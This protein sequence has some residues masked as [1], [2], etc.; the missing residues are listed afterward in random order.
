VSFG[1]YLARPRGAPIGPLRAEALIRRVRGGSLSPAELVWKEGFDGWKKI[2]QVPELIGDLL[3]ADDEAAPDTPPETIRE[4]SLR[5]DHEPPETKRADVP[6]D[7]LKRARGSVVPTP[8]RSNDGADRAAVP[9]RALPDAVTETNPALRA[10]AEEGETTESLPPT[11]DFG[12][13]GLVIVTPGAPAPARP[14]LALAP[15]ESIPSH[16]LRLPNA[17]AHPGD[18]HP[19]IP[20]YDE[21]SYEQLMAEQEDPPPQSAPPPPYPTNFPAPEPHPPP[22]PAPVVSV[23]PAKPASNAARSAILPASRGGRWVLV[24]VTLLAVALG[25]LAARYVVRMP[26]AAERGAP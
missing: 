5:F 8:G 21:A 22:A 14:R 15:A 23:A 2:A 6:A 26:R 12:S 16:T 1:W 3:G 17:P 9:L 10:Q 11:L 13:R 19:V 25:F 24:L 20:I 18:K 4:A 7:V